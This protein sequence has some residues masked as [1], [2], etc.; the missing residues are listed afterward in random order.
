MVRIII[1]LL[2]Y[3]M[4]SICMAQELSTEQNLATEGLNIY[5]S[6][7]KI[8]SDKGV[9]YYA[10]YDSE[11][12]FNN[13]QGYQYVS[14]EVKNGEAKAV[15]KNLQP[16]S[17]AIL[18]FHDENKNGKMDFDQNGMP[19]EYYGVSNNV[20]SYGPPTFTDAKFD[21][22]DKDLTFEIAF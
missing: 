6:T 3:M 8:T 4:G 9:V 13:R 18:C 7:H 5:V 16:K 10:L 14:S 20:M 17:Y 11:E 19:I 15:F 21:L 1:V 22:R 2:S 12:A